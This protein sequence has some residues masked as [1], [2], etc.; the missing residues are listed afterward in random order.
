MPRYLAMLPERFQWT[1]R[2]LVAHPLSEVLFQ[3][4]FEEWSNWVHDIT[5]PEH[6]PGTGR[7]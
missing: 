5:I 2:N 6:E 7:G 1:L 3:V 4:G